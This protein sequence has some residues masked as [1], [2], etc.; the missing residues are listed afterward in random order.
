MC[1]MNFLRLKI[2]FIILQTKERSKFSKLKP[3]SELQN[4]VGSKKGSLEKAFKK[5]QR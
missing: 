5:V 3:I 4:R 1:N 2:N